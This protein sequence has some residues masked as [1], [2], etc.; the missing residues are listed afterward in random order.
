ME[1]RERDTGIIYLMTA[2][3]VT[4]EIPHVDGGGRLA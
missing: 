1:E 3:F 2:G 4:G